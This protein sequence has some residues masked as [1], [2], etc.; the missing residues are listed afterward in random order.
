M[1]YVIQTKNGEEVKNM[2]VCRRAL[3]A[4][5]Y[6]NVFVPKYIC[7]KRY[8]G[9]W[10]YEQRV[11]F[12]GYFF[13]DTNQPEAVEEALAPL[14]RIMK[15]VC[16]GKEFHPIYEEEQRFLESLMDSEYNILMS[17]GNIVSGICDVEEGPLRKKTAIIRK[18]NRHKRTADIEVNLFGQKRLVKIGLEIVSKT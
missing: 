1:W 12:S 6:C 4:C 16:V 17:R 9:A 14:D 5:S 10:H 3:K 15:P 8:E 2:D 7:M 18:V 13:I 11:L